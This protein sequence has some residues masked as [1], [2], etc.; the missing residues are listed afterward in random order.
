MRRLAHGGVLSAR[1]GRGRL[2]ARHPGFGKQAQYVGRPEFEYL[3]ADEFGI[4]WG[5]GFRARAGVVP[6]PAMHIADPD[7]RL[8]R[9]EPRERGLRTV[10]VGQVAR[11]GADG[12]LCHAWRRTQRQVAH[13]WFRRV[14]GIEDAE[15]QGRRGLDADEG[16]VA[17]A[18]EVAY[19]DHEHIVPE[20]PGGP[21]VTK[22]PRG[23]G[24]PGDVEMAAR[25]S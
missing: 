17:A 6:D 10:G 12:N 25:S 11:G 1:G 23:P 21:G 9:N 13:S 20:Y 18:V 2:A 4:V 8:T 16:R 24:F 14:K 3:G 7:R 15:K 19:P 22:S 5:A